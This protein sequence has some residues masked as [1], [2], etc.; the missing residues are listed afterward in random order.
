M[1]KARALLL[2]LLLCLGAWAQSGGGQV[3]ASLSS[4]SIALDETATLTLSI[5]GL[6]GDVDIPLPE[7]R[8][9]GLQFDYAGQRSSTT[10]MNGQISSSTELDYR[11][12]PVRKGRHLIE[13]ITGNVGGTPFTAKTLRLEVTEAGTGTG[14]SRSANSNPWSSGI[15]GLNPTNPWAINPA[16]PWAQPAF[17]EPEPEEDA[18]LEAVVEPATVYKHQPV[19][20][21]LRLLVTGHLLSDPRYNPIAPT[22]FLRV[23][24]PQEN[25]QEERNGHLYN[26]MS[27][28][29]AYF[30]LS[31]GEYTFDP[32]QV[33]ISGGFFSLPQTLT[34]EPRTVKVLPLPSEGRPQSFTGAVGSQF[35][36]QAQLKSAQISLGGNTELQVSV[37]GD[38]H[39]DLVPYPFLPQWAGLEK[40]QMSSPSTTRV[41]NGAIASSR[42]YN[43]RLK[44]TK[45]GT[46]TLSGIA[47]A[48]FNPSEERYEVV[49]APDLTLRVEPNRNADPSRPSGDSDVDD[50]ER[51]CPSPGPSSGRLPELPTIPM[52][53]SAVLLLSGA[54]LA[55]PRRRSSGTRRQSGKSVAAKHKTLAEF[56]SALETL[57]PDSDSS[58]RENS[59]LAKG[60]SPES[61][62]RY[63]NLKR[64]AGRALFGG[65]EP[66]P[67]VLEDLNKELGA[68]LKEAK[69]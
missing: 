35:E 39:L 31:E 41:E 57:A 22:G 56:M 11:V 64:S 15:N 55:R 53:A 6:S 12:T 60:W 34:T 37:K 28:K 20:Y 10:Y 51:P 30:P 18:Q 7:S 24:F 45:E 1:V 2:V 44:P 47:L 17:P 68:L 61:I 59:L 21:N 48:Y 32:S 67:G 66:N 29:T 62:A 27:V 36:I 14:Q 5:T 38:G 50:S 4:D 9:G 33:A 25:S 65:G 58:A 49:K 26:V 3:T 52:A 8:D 46:Y 63:E 13:E 54:I 23:A 69:R 40:K 19:F 43:F 42:T 16:N